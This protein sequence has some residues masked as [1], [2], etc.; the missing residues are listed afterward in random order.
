MQ[1]ENRFRKHELACL[2][3]AL[4]DGNFGRPTGSFR[5]RHASHVLQ[6]LH[7][8]LALKPLHDVMALKSYTITETTSCRHLTLS[9]SGCAQRRPLHAVVERSS[10]TL[11]SFF[12]IH[13]HPMIYLQ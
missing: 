4:I 3:K 6:P 10:A 2:R 9:I 1:W 8:V 13:S 7:D 11:R 12:L 5:Y